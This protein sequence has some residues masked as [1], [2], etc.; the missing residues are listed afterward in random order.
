MSQSST[1]F[2]LNHLSIRTVNLEKTCDF[3]DRVMGFKKGARPN[4]PFPGAW[5]YNGTDDDYANAIIH[6][7]GIDPNDP[8]GLKKYLGDRDLNSLQGTG[9]IDHIAFFATDLSG[10]LK[11]LQKQSIPYRERTVPSLDLHQIF[12]DDPNGVVIELNY[13]ASEKAALAST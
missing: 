13:P 8:E 7:I 3:F 4:F 10:M 5:L 11:N 12:V 6:I 2:S 9:A 1:N